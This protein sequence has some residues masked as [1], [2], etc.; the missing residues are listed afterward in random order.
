LAA[1]SGDVQ[2]FSSMHICETVNDGAMPTRLSLYRGPHH[3]QDISNAL[4][5]H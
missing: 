4:L 2:L 5:S 3:L 1:G